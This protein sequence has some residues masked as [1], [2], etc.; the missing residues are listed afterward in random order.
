MDSYPKLLL[1]DAQGKSAA[2]EEHF[3]KYTVGTV[4]Q[5]YINLESYRLL[6]GQMIC[7]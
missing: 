1:Q 7:Y 5:I 4:Q 2:N 3:Q 6:R